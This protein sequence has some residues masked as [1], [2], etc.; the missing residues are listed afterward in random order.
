MAGCKLGGAPR[1]IAYDEAIEGPRD[2]D[3]TK[4]GRRIIKG[5]AAV[6]ATGTGADAA[7]AGAVA[8]TE[9]AGTGS[10]LRETAAPVVAASTQATAETNKRSIP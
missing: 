9:P 8:T 4:D 3:S 10:T 6:G 5:A 1:P 7:A 2:R